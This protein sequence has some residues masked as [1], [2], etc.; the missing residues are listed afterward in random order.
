MA[1]L[2]SSQ[3]LAQKVVVAHRGASGYLPEHT[4]EAKSMAYAMGADYVEQDVVMT[5]DD[6]LI[7]I[8]DITLDRTTDVAEKFPGRARGDGRHYVIDFTLAEIRTLAL[9][10]GARL[11]D[12]KR[13][14]GF[15]SRFPMGKSSFRIAT[16]AEELELVQGLNIS[17]GR[18]V[19]IYPEIKSP[20]FHLAEG[21]DLGRAVV[22]ELK[23]YGYTSKQDPIFLQTFGWEEVKRLRDEILP[24]AG[25]DLKLV[26]L[27]GD[28]EDYQWM[29]SPEGMAEV[30]RYA[31][32]FGPDKSLLIDPESK[33]GQL[34]VSRLVEL[35]HANGMQVHPYTFRADEGQLEP[36]AESFEDML[37]A[38]FF[39]ADIDGAFTD[40]PDRAVNFLRDR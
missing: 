24:E 22:A 23:K 26:Q 37:E 7:V 21:K 19:G 38:F 20:E 18:Q 4:L 10:E 39:E 12:G 6:Q 5:K 29:F 2:I 30:G 1:S 3:A 34:K 31:D 28:T 14:Q 25:I 11:V 33:P 32:G 13:E 9:S 27:V 36:W 17:T 35:A 16:L 8:H 40:F 15:K